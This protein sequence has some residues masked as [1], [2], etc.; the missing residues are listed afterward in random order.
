[1][2]G[3]MYVIDGNFVDPLYDGTRQQNWL[4]FFGGV[5]DMNNGGPPGDVVYGRL[6]NYVAARKAARPWKVIVSTVHATSQSDG[7]PE[8]N[9]L[10]NACIRTNVGGWDGF[11]DPGLNSP[12]ETR[13]NDYAN[14]NYYYYSGTDTGLHLINAG[15]SVFADHFGQIVNVPHRTTGFFAP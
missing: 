3:S 13:L 1:V 9:A 7:H 10:F 2:A 4:L 5:N 14:T 8:M 15:Y 11:V 6:T 12:I